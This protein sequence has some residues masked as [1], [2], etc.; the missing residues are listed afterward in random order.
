SALDQAVQ[1]LIAQQRGISLAKSLGRH[2]RNAVPMYANIN[3]A[4]T[5]RTPDGFAA[6]ARAALNDGF[7]AIKIAPFDGVELYGDGRKA[8]DQALIE[9]AI[10]R[11]AGVRDAIGPRAE[12]M[13]DCHW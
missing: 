11:I 12:L 4:I 5:N 7:T 2:C 8:A 1:D 9:A 10:A 6:A 3:R 13:V